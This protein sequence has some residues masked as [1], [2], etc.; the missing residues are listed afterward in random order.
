MASCNNSNLTAYNPSSSNPW[1]VSKIKFIY[2]RLGFGISLEKA[3]TK[4]GFTP[5]ELIDQIIDNAKNL[6]LTTAPEWGYWNNSQINQ[7]GKNQSY[8]KNIW[9]RQA[10]SNFLNDG[11]RE[12][13]TLFWSNHFV[14]E[15]Y[16][17][18]RAPYLFQ[19]HIKLQKHSLGN[20]KE[21]VSEIGLEP[22]MLLYLNG[23]SNR[24][25]APNENYARELY[26]L[27]TLGEGNGYQ[28]NDIT[29]TA[30]ALTGY[31]KYSDGNG[32][33]IIF[34]SNTFDNG[35]KTIFGKTGNW[36]YQDVIDILFNEKKDLIAKFI[37][38]K[39]YKYFISPKVENEIVNQLAATFVSN[40]FNLT[41]VYKLLFK[42]EHF[43][44]TN[45]S[46]VLIK[47]PIDTFVF[48]QNDFEFDFPETFQSNYLNYIKNKCVEMG[49][50]IFKPVD[51]AGWQE[52]HDWI[53][54]GTLPMR[55]EFLEYIIRRHW[56]K[57]K[58][59]FRSFIIELVGNDEKNPS[60]I[61]S[62]M[63]D[64]MFC[65]FDM[66]PEEMLDAVNVFKG[67]TPENYYEDGT[68][69]L[70]LES[71][72]NQVFNLM[73]FFINLPEYQLK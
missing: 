57:N 56:V 65:K 63:K 51:V 66:K 23:Y 53:S 9:Q 71:V 29:E 6:P 32:S 27:F 30:R 43:F 34:N 21:F 60:T 52:N 20:F 31:N 40:D 33:S 54:T 61:V 69:T 46:N 19:Y 72:P 4:L 48:L 7:S 38:Q 68:W 73:L 8:Y 42:S 14:T 25:Q 59:Q 18:N 55:W 39:L 44:D 3:K 36:G 45:S 16:D 62:K 41:P 1:D 58:E 13:I 28:S 5:S 67:D 37:C 26:E 22:A 70:S 35:D 10:F 47:S 17:Y 24:K 64:Y 12:R 15:Y 11:F 50:E 2:R 49:Q